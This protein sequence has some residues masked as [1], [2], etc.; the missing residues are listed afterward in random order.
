MLEERRSG[1]RLT[2]AIVHMGM[3]EMACPVIY[4]PRRGVCR[5]LRHAGAAAASGAGARERGDH[6]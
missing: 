3:A 6:Q 1:G 2:C 5:D 4:R